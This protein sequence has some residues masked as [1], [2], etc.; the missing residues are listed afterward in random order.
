MTS[1]WRYIENHKSCQL[2]LGKFQIIYPSKNCLTV[3]CVDKKY[4]LKFY[5]KT[6]IIF[7]LNLNIFIFDKYDSIIHKLTIALR[8]WLLLDCLKRSLSYFFNMEKQYKQLNIYKKLL[9][10][11]GNNIFNKKYFLKT[12]NMAWSIKK[13]K[14]APW[15]LTFMLNLRL[16]QLAWMH[17]YSFSFL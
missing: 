6:I 15:F 17:L 11:C 12:L 3:S 16:K 8:L 9:L 5:I 14:S 7:V 13:P 4:F 10:D 2:C 1:F